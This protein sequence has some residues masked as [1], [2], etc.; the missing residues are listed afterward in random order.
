MKKNMNVLYVIKYLNLKLLILIIYKVK[1]HIKNIENLKQQLELEEQIIFDS[2]TINDYNNIKSKETNIDTL[3]SATNSQ[4]ET[5]IPIIVQEEQ[6]QQSLENNKIVVGNVIP[7]NNNNNNTNN[8]NNNNTNDDDSF[9][10]DMSYQHVNEKDKNEDDAFVII[11]DNDEKEDLHIESDHLLAQELSNI[12]NNNN[13]NNNMNNNNMN[14][15]NNNNSYYNKTILLVRHGQAFN[16]IKP[17]NPNLLIDPGLTDN[18]K[19]Q[20]EQLRHSLFVYLKFDAIFVSP[21]NRT[22]ETTCGALH[23]KDVPVM[24]CELLRERMAPQ[25]NRRKSNEEKKKSM[26]G[27]ILVYVNIMKMFYLIVYV[28]MKV[29]KP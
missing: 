4:T 22:L 19:S 20:C 6:Q 13:N 2:L 23:D 1:K 12:N 10:L 21:M 24:A 17:S 18:G 16:N 28:K 8:N 3:S 7:S 5:Q 25:F 15:M 14:N 29:M 11:N 9:V 27:L 26:I